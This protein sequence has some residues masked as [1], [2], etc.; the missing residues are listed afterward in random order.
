MCVKN[1]TLLFGG[2]NRYKMD[3]CC[4]KYIKKVEQ[5]Y[6]FLMDFMIG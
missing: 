2:N 4:K 6:C 5:I 1:T 3:F